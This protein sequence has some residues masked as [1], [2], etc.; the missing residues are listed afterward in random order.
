M[1]DVNQLTF[2]G[3]SMCH[4]SQVNR[5]GSFSLCTVTYVFVFYSCILGHIMSYYTTLFD[6]YFDQ[7]VPVV[8]QVHFDQL[9]LFHS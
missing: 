7:Q 4:Q 8:N 2:S 1:Q 5:D 9:C 3:V 6:K